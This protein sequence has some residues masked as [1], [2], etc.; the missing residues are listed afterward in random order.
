MGKRPFAGSSATGIAANL[1]DRNFVGID[2]E[3]AFLKLSK[4][5]KLEIENKNIFNTY[6]TNLLQ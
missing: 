6:K 2:K 1:L 3:E 4:K 5:R